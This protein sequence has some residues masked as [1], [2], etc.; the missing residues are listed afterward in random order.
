ME[1]CSVN[2][3]DRIFNKSRARKE[4]NSYLKKSL[5]K[6]A[7]KLA[8]F[9]K[10]ESLSEATLLDVGCGVGGLHLELLKHGA[11]KAIG[12]DLSPA[13]VEAASSLARE[14]GFQNVVE[15][16]VGDFVEQER[17]I[18]TADIVLLDRVVCCYPDMEPLVTAYARHAQRLYALTYPR[19][20]WWMRVAAFMMNL[21][22]SV[23]RKQFRFFLHH[24]REMEATLA[25]EG[26]TPIF[27]TTSTA[28]IWQLA[29]YQRQ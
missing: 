20:T 9:L 17:D 12:V 27:R 8:D 6:R 28:G 11:G 7:R 13:Y 29:I 21:G 23:I 19:R 26:F 1:C 24:P 10:G 15:Y 3:L 18:P 5:D 16:H 2:G 4:S 22:L 25:S 14:L